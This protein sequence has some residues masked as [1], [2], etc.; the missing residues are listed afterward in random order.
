MDGQS[1]AAPERI[2]R[3]PEF[4]RILQHRREDSR[5]VHDA[6]RHGQWQRC[7]AVRRRRHAKTRVGCR[8]QPDETARPG[9]V[10]ATKKI[11]GLDIVIGPRREMLDAPFAILEAEYVALLARRRGR[12]RVLRIYKV[13]LSPLF[14]GSC[15]FY[16]RAPTT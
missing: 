8:A 5:P 11:G 6:V 1:L 2:R 10:Q 16:P 12:D 13:F 3:R 4:E 14:T 7:A 15:R 9:A